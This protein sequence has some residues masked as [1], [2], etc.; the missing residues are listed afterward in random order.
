MSIDS[1]LYSLGIKR[2]ICPICRVKMQYKVEGNRYRHFLCPKCGS[3]V[4]IPKEV[5]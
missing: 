4:K 5:K 3:I 2:A 1:L